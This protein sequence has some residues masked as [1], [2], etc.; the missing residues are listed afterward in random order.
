MSRNDCRSVNA[1]AARSASIESYASLTPLR[2]AS[3]KISSGSSEPSM[4]MCSSAFG[5]PATLW[6][7]EEGVVMLVGSLFLSVEFSFALD[8]RCACPSC[9]LR[10]RVCMSL[11]GLQQLGGRRD[12]DDLRRLV[13]DPVDA[14]RAFH[15]R[16]LRRI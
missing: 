11:D 8:A 1:Y 15:P 4:W 2:S 13:D 12:G 3:R 5:A 10:R 7:S 6:A 9:G 16:N 14:E